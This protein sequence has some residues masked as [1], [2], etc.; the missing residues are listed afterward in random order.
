M[1]TKHTKSDNNSVVHFIEPIALWEWKLKFSTCSICRI[2]LN[3]ATFISS[4]NQQYTVHEEHKCTDICIGECNHIFHQY[5]IKNWTRI[6][7]VCPLCNKNW[8]TK[9][10]K[11][12]PDDK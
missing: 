9:D 6:R 8:V 4:E 5:C 2:N 10:T 11:S 7:N 1:S 12:Y 3:Q